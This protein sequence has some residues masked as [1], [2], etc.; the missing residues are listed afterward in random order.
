MPVM[1]RNQC[2]NKT[3]SLKAVQHVKPNLN[4][5]VKPT[6]NML[7]WFIATV[8]EG[9]VFIEKHDTYVR[10]IKVMSLRQGH[11]ANGY[12]QQLRFL[13]FDRIRRMTEMMYFIDQ[14]LLEAYY[15]SF[16]M[17][18]FIK[19]LYNKIQ[20][21]YRDIH[22]IEIQPETDDERK[23]I[24]ALIYIIQ[25]LEKTV[26]PL[27]QPELPMKRNR[28]VVDYTGMDTIEP[29]NEFDGITDIWT[30]ETLSK[31]SDY[32]PSEESEEDEWMVYNYEPECEDYE[33]GEESEEDEQYYSEDEDYVPDDNNNL[34]VYEDNEV[35]EI[36][37][38]S[39]KQDRCKVLKKGNHTRFIYDDEV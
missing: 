4:E 2:I 15:R 14:Y 7:H 19:T 12:K 18:E 8:K 25:D 35:F 22:T 34:A 29:D 1:T 32:E 26:I 3:A 6:V 16:K 30:D 5:T 37:V 20:E 31:D 9:L 38:N 39:K 13:H 27:L 11:R 23:T 33:E 10:Q 24:A 28:K 21:L 17:G 36:L